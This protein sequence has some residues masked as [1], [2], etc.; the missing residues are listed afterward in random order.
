MFTTEIIIWRYL[1]NV[2]KKGETEIDITLEINVSFQ[3]RLSRQ[4]ERHILLYGNCD[5]LEDAE[6][7]SWRLR[8]NRSLGFANKKRKWIKNGGDRVTR[9]R[10]I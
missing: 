1:Y 5:E 8:P 4:L 3:G 10:H 9:V 6:D 7:I 2:N